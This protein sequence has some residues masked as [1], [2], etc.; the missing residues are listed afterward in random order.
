MKVDRLLND[1]CVICWLNINAFDTNIDDIRFEMFV[2][3]IWK[4]SKFIWEIIREL[5][6]VKVRDV[7]E[8]MSSMIDDDANSSLILFEI[9]VYWIFESSISNWY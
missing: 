5:D 4:T 9:S 1:Q 2:V 6:F 7:V 8:M 3:S